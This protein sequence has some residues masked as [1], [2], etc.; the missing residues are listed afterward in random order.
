MQW[1]IVNYDSFQAAVEELCAFLSARE[2]PQEKVF[3]S[4]LVVHELVGNA[5]Q[6]AEGGARV[7][8]EVDGEFIRLSIHGAAAYRPPKAGKCPPCF[9]ERGRGFFLVDSVSEERTC[10]EDGV[11]LVRI[12]IR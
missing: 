7:C 8:V 2:I 3:D 1:S 9:A 4:K 6:H 11:I 12:K 10:T 5:L